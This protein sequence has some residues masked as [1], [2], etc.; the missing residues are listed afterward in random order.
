MKSIKHGFAEKGEK[1]KKDLSAKIFFLS[2]S[3]SK[4]ENN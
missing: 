4:L 1:K 2:K 3:Y